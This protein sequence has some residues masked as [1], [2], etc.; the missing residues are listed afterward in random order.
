MLTNLNANIPVY[1]TFYH[2]L[3]LT[4]NLSCLYTI[5]TTPR[6]R[7]NSSTVYTKVYEYHEHCGDGDN[8]HDERFGIAE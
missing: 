3:K 7:S 5:S 6:K 8:E 4:P 2:F 1:T